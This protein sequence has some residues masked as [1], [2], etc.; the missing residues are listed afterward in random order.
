MI[1]RVM[2]KNGH[3]GQYASAPPPTPGGPAPFTSLGLGHQKMRILCSAPNRDPAGFLLVK[4]EWDL[5]EQ[6][7]KENP[8]RRELNQQERN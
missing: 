5:A 6:W 8:D 4:A 3:S 1:G 2:L 7:L